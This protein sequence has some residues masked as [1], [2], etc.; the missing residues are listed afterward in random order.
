MAIQGE[1][2]PLGNG[3]RRPR[4]GPDASLRGASGY[5]PGFGPFRGRVCTGSATDGDGTGSTG[6]SPA[7]PEVFARPWGVVTNVRD[8]HVWPDVATTELER[9][10]HGC[11]EGNA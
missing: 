2:D 10:G 9:M 6:G 4:A 8:F 7:R 5:D 1:P 3:W 11:H